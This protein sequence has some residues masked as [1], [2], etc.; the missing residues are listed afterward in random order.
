MKGS[1]E[2]PICRGT[3]KVAE[4]AQEYE[5]ETRDSITSRCL[6]C[7]GSGYVGAYKKLPDGTPARELHKLHKTPASRPRQ[8][9]LNVSKKAVINPE[10]VDTEEAANTG[11]ARAEQ[12]NVEGD[13]PKE[14]P[15]F[16][17]MALDHRLN[18]V[19]GSGKQFLI[20]TETEPY[21][22]VVYA[23]IRSQEMKK[24]TWTW[25][26]ENAYVEA[27]MTERQR[28]ITIIASHNRQVAVPAKEAMNG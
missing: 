13:E 21:Y 4:N 28:L 20:I 6:I 9:R 3:G 10:A 5:F 18:K 15:M 19:L 22:L 8:S 14:K 2:C 17:K 23:M 12:N 24:N 7:N 16:L 1:I 11:I 26:D 27:I 25:E